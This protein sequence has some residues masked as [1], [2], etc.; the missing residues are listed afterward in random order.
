VTVAQRLGRL[1]QRVDRQLP[2][3]VPRLTGLAFKV[4][5]V[6]WVA[7]LALAIVGTIGGLRLRLSSPPENWQFIP[8]SKAG[9]AVSPADGTLVRFPV[10]PQ[11]I[12]SEFIRGDRIVAIY[13]IPLPAPMPLSEEA[14][15]DHANNT[16]YIVFAN[17]LWSGENPEVPLTVR[18]PDG[19]LRDVTVVTGEYHI[20]E[21]A[22]ELSIS[23]RLLSFLDLVHVLFYP[24]L[25]WIA[26]SLYTRNASQPVPAL[27]SISILFN[28]VSEQPASALWVHI[29]VPRAL[30]V[31]VYDC[32][33][34]MLIA[35]L[36]LFP[37]GRL[38]PRAI[39]IPM[40]LLTVIFFEQGALYQFTIV[41]AL[42]FALAIF[43]KRLR[44][45]VGATRR[46]FKL[47]LAGLA[48][49]PA[50]RGLSVFLDYAKWSASSLSQQ[51]LMETGAG[52]AFALCS[53]P[54][55]LVVFAA[56][57]RHRLYDADA[58]IPRSV[59]I[60]ALTLTIA[61]FFAAA[62]ASLQFAADFFLGQDTGPWPSLVA[63]A[64]AVLLINPV[65]RRIHSG[66]E[67]FL[68]KDLFTFRTELPKRMD[69]LRE[70]E[71]P[72]ALLQV[73][74]EDIARGL[75]AATSAA[76]LKGRV[77]ASTG[78]DRKDVRRWMRSTHL[79]DPP[80]LSCNREDHLFPV[81]LPLRAASGTQSLVGWI[82]LGPRPD[83]SIY[84]REERRALVEVEESVSRAVEVARQRQQTQSADR[85]WRER[86]ERRLEEL[87]AQLAAL[88]TVRG[89]RKLTA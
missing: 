34:V 73:A 21:A 36:L 53:L 51:L 70:T 5:R 78:T 64:A 38:R 65:Q 12:G 42:A 88:A 17:L 66:T 43:I 75:G 72:G 6:L 18:D 23:P 74:L 89:P 77:V 28:M 4:F 59:M 85:R 76:I 79:P 50:L 37:D 84:S 29:G 82:V 44:D 86:Q 68:Q 25:F 58:L 35:T 27:L 11:P 87:E 83:G 9:F 80:R 2:D 57:R 60:A 16:A 15:A 19:R 24:I 71:P 7:A 30:D 54:L 63:A 55:F 32:A 10:G 67:R 8:G 62:S 1:V 33:N 61:A 52:V 69:D 45:V 47:L 39:L 26:F 31:A 13:G 14:L 49:F 22:R 40:S 46:Q 81:R 3:R 20:D 48:M 56:L 41:L